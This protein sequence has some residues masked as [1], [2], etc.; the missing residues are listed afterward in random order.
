MGFAGDLG[1][2]VKVGR[3]WDALD[4]DFRR[5]ALVHGIDANRWNNHVLK[6]VPHTNRGNDWFLDYRTVPDIETGRR[7]ADW[8]A[9]LRSTVTNTPDLRL[10]AVMTG[11]ANL[12]TWRRVALT[13][14]FMLKSWP[15]MVVRN[16]SLPLL[17][18][19][20][21]GRI[22]PLAAAATTLFA[23]GMLTIQIKNLIDG[24][25]PEA[26]SM[27]LARRSFLQGGI[28][29]LVFDMAAQDQ[30][31]LNSMARKVGG[32]VV[33]MADD[34]ASIAYA[35]QDW[36]LSPVF[37]MEGNQKLGKE[38]LRVM[39]RYT[40]LGNLWYAQAAV[41]RLIYNTVAQ[42]PGVD[43]D[44]WDRRAN[45]DQKLMNERGQDHWWDSTSSM[46]TLF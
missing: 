36:M 41:D 25:E 39:N 21:Q 8:N 34:L 27:D 4:E 31:F 24:K 45:I 10:R 33:G 20:L 38:I 12:G 42:L 43:P 13:S 32:P 6:G 9:A 1:A 26:L 5:A 14:M 22:T 35:A 29:G 17:N 16:M 37:G 44:F 3:M 7:L 46:Q 30:G 23:T 15:I 19:A 2:A 28:G 18:M 11:G 40:P